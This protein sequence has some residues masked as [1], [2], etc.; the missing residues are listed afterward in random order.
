L[1]GPGETVPARERFATVSLLET[2]NEEVYFDRRK[3]SRF[4]RQTFLEL[5]SGDKRDQETA[6]QVRK[7]ILEGQRK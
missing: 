4:T 3:T 2:Q 1:P 5:S 6:T 7:A